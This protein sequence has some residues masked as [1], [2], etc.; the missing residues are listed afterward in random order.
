MHKEEKRVA[1]KNNSPKARKN[2][3]ASKEEIKP[4][5][6]ESET[7]IASKMHGSLKINREVSFTEES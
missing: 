6:K 2:K 1:T 7:M 5:E 3:L 4:E